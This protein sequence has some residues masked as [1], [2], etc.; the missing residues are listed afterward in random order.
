MSSDRRSIDRVLPGLRLLRTYDTSWLPA[1][2]LAGLSVAAIAVP[3]AI[4]YSQL[5]GVPP[6]NGLYAS[7]L[8]LIAYAFFGTSRQLIMA[9]DAATCALVA[10]TIAPLAGDDPQRYISLTMVLTVLAGLMCIG[11]GIAKLG[12]LTTFL[13]RPILTGY[14]NGI[15]LSII[16]GQLGKL[17]GF[18]LQ[19]KGFFRLLWEFVSKLEQ[20]HVMT[21]VVG[22]AVSVLLLVVKRLFRNIPA[23]LVGVAVGILAAW[24]FD[25]GGRGV[26]LVGTIPAGLPSLMVPPVTAAD[27]SELFLGAAGLALISFNS[28][29][30]T[31]RG[32]AVK[33]GY[34]LDPDQEFIALGVANIGAG[35]LQGFAISGADSRTAINDS[36]GGKTQVTGLVAAAVFVVVLL[37]LTGPLALLPIP[38]LAAVLIMAGQSLFDVHGLLALRRI[39]PGEFGLSLVATLGVVSVGVLPGVIVAVALAIILLLARA[40]RPHDAILGRIPGVDGYQDIESHEGAETLPG[41]VIYRFDAAL[42]FFNADYFKERVRKVIA[43][44]D[45]PRWLLLDAEAMSYVDTTGAAILEEVRE[46]LAAHG[47][48]MA[49]SRARPPVRT[50]LKRTGFEDRIG[51]DRFYPTVRTAVDAI[52]QKAIE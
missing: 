22:L 14:L 50:I 39:H 20:T 24:A 2:V 47:T 21:L 13:A 7:I 19:S 1:D 4:A 32:F 31:A 40:S 52:L 36:V 15:A 28:A 18:P 8:P 43:A 23:P 51:A 27:L 5:A 38:V 49:V 11:G 34:D 42:V 9:P 41:L 45:S 6:V 35:V 26:A 12:F 25:L 44:A 46:T 30:V 48:A 17:F 33:N 29:M 3:I 10:A 16:S 37:F